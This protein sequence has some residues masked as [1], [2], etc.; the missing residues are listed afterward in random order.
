MKLNSFMP[1][2]NGIMEK[3]EQDLKPKI[4]LILVKS[5]ASSDHE[6]I[7]EIQKLLSE[8]VFSGQKFR[9]KLTQD[10]EDQ[11]VA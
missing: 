3:I 10:E 1:K 5:G 9:K 7:L 4:R 11:N 6:K 2:L 8:I